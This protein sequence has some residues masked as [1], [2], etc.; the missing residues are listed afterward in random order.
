MPE[1]LDRRI[2]SPAGLALWAA[3]LLIVFAAAGLFFWSRMEPPLPSGQAAPQDAVVPSQAARGDASVVV[4]L[5]YP[6]RGGG[7]TTDSLGVKRQFDAQSQAREALSAL[8]GY[9]RT[10]QA[11]VIRDLRLRA[12]YLDPAG[13]AY[14][15]LSPASEQRDVRGSAWEELMAIYAVVNTLTQNFEE[16]KE[17]R[18]L[19]DGREA[20]TLAGHIDASVFFSARPDL[21]KQ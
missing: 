20:Q 2:S 13:T 14:V 18:F 11:A 8:F 12:F 21:V 15:D 17:V 9:Q 3:V 1:G 5:Y 19:L 10:G 4:M 7:L 6:A 16:I